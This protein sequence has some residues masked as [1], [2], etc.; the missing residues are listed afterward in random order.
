M[1]RTHRLPFSRQAQLLGLSRSSVYYRPVPTS[2]PDLRTMRRIDELHLELPF[3]GARMLRDLLGLEGWKIGR[4][5]VTT[6]M[7]RMGI[8][9]IYCRKNASRAH[10][11]H[12][13]FPE[14]L[15]RG[16]A[17]CMLVHNHPSGVSEPS[18]ADELITQRLRDALQL[19][20]IRVIDHLVVSSGGVTS[21]AERGL[22]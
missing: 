11:G 12:A 10:P 8:E 15:K 3:A 13:V 19:V 20:D 22:L 2:D 9:A 16:A 1:D 6:L 18:T 14:A 5:H 17:A 21:F 4:K 7:R